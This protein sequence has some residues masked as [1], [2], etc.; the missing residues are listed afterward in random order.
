M[1]CSPTT[2]ETTP[3]IASGSPKLK[4]SLTSG[5]QVGLRVSC[6]RVVS[7]LGSREGCKIHIPDRRISPVH[8]AFI[9]DGS[10]IKAI[11]L[12]SKTGTK[13]NDL[14][15]EYETLH[16]GDVIETASW[17]FEAHIQRTPNYDQTDE[18]VLDADLT[19]QG[20]MLEHLSSGRRLQPNRDVC[21]IGRRAGCDIHLDDNRVSRTHAL[22]MTY[23]G[24]PAIVDLLTGNGTFVNG[25]SVAFRKLH[26]G[27]LLK[28][29][30][31]EFRVQ[32]GAPGVGSNGLPHRD[33]V[34]K[35]PRL[36]TPENDHP[37]D[38]INIAETEGSQRWR[39][40][41]KTKKVARG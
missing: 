7:L 38:Q 30:E 20:I 21:I 4:L 26:S 37:D 40:A 17:S 18:H 16:H 24:R 19:P 11:D 10:S 32:L 28:I 36:V 5:S 41:E 3:T 14:T 13:L 31:S 34:F 8:L 22:L 6:H 25:E 9:N 29:G 39:I 2:E 27:D 1:A 23:F 35:K 15:L 12:L 33:A